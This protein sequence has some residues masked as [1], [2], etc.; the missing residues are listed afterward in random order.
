MTGTH[1]LGLR[2]AIAP[3][4]SSFPPIFLSPART[5]ITTSLKPYISRAHAH[6]FLN[7]CS[8]VLLVDSLDYSAVASAI[9]PL[10]K[11]PSHAQPEEILQVILVL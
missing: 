1:Y 5:P 6:D 11:L 9:A 3:C 7:R 4:M 8:R 10:F 2:C